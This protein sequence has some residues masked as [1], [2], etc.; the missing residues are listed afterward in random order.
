MNILNIN[1]SFLLVF[2][3]Y[4]NIKSGRWEICGI[5]TKYSEIYVIE[6]GKR[7]QS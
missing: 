3:T 1:M 7:W 6:N 5:Y 4:K 2:Q